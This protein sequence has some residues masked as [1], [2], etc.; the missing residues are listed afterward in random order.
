MLA[1]N[2]SIS[3][4][5]SNIRIPENRKLD[6]SKYQYECSEYRFK[7]MSRYQTNDYTLL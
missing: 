4:H 6:I 1:L 3:L 2:T 7:V 5:K